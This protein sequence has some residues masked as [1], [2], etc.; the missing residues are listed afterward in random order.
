MTVRRT[1]QIGR[2][3]MIILGHF[4]SRFTRDHCWAT[5]RMS[6]DE[7]EKRGASNG[8][9]ITYRESEVVT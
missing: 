1:S 5:R 2:N 9:A 4:L 3:E 8:N 7:R 6:I